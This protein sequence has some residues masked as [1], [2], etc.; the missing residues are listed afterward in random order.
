MTCKTCRVSRPNLLS[1]VTN[2]LSIC[3]ALIN[4][5][6]LLSSLR[7]A[8]FL[9]PLIFSVKTERTDQPFC[10]HE[11]TIKARK[12][13]IYGPVTNPGVYTYV[14]NMTLEDAIVAAGGL[15]EE[16][17]LSN[18]EIARRLQYTDEKDSTYNKKAQVYTFD[19][20]ESY[21][22]SAHDRKAL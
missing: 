21:C 3:C 19:E 17:L 13:H 16:A 4:S 9:A 22:V 7:S 1:S 18:I 20:D 15:K 5:I 6:I 14:E 8:F 12:Y 10:V 2:T 11:E